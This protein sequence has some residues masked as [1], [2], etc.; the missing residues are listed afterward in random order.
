MIRP[1]NNKVNV[2]PIQY[3]NILFLT[4]FIS[5]ILVSLDVANLSS[6]HD[7]LLQKGDV[8]CKVNKFS[9]TTL[10]NIL[11]IIL[12]KVVF[13]THFIPT[14]TIQSYSGPVPPRNRR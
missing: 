11:F 4:F 7:I 13:L 8:F 10:N 6:E 3:S 9:N 2:C 5:S 1:V 14:I 12:M